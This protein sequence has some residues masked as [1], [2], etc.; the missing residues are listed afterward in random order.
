MQKTN[1]QTTL[2]WWVMIGLSE[3][4]FPPLN[5]RLS[6]SANSI[7]SSCKAANASSTRARF[8]ARRARSSRFLDE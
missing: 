6:S 7:S 4:S 3:S 2:T 5:S 8:H 1:T